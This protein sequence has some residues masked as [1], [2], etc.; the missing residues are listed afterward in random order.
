MKTDEELIIIIIIIIIII[1]KL[2]AKYEKKIIKNANTNIKNMQPGYKKRIWS[3]KMCN[4]DNEK[5]KRRNM[6]KK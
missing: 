5:W 2:L 3:R 1:T 6:R 4:A